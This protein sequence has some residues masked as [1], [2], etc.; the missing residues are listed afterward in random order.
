[1]G[2]IYKSRR[3]AQFMGVG[4]VLLGTMCVGIAE[5]LQNQ[6]AFIPIMSVGVVVIAAGV[7]VMVLT[8]RC[9]LCDRPV[10][11]LLMALER[12]SC[13]DACWQKNQMAMGPRPAQRA[14]LGTI[15][16]ALRKDVRK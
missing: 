4:I 16:N 2:T 12:H 3:N 15:D 7:G 10:N 14:D 13:C 11:Y 6:S 1:M 8:S 9:P 5:R